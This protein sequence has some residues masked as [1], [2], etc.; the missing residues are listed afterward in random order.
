VKSN[1]KGISIINIGLGLKMKFRVREDRERERERVLSKVT[2]NK[3]LEMAFQLP[4]SD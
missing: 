3:V 4:S 2:D 1:E